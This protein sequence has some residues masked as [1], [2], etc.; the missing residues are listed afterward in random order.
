MIGFC[1]WTVTTESKTLVQGE[2]RAQGIPLD[3]VLVETVDLSAIPQNVS[4]ATISLTL[5]DAMG[6][7]LSRYHREVFLKAWQVG[8]NAAPTVPR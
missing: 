5:T 1:A 6:K 7:P 2:K 3:A 4:V 8:P